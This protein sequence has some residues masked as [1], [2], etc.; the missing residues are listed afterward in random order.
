[1]THKP[2]LAQEHTAIVVQ[3]NEAEHLREA[4]RQRDEWDAYQI[5]CESLMNYGR[6]LVLIEQQIAAEAI[7]GKIL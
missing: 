3:L 7:G 6:R 5:V 4:Y 2:T 1:M